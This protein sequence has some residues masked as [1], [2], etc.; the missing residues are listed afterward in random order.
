M[1][2]SE[3]APDEGPADEAADLAGLSD[4]VEGLPPVE[5]SQ[6]WLEESKRRLLERFHELRAKGDP[7]PEPPSS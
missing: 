6:R 1:Q 5:P 3:P 4:E 7:R 2:D